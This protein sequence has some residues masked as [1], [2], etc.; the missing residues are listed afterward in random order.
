MHVTAQQNTSAWAK[1]GPM[2]RASADP[3]SPYYGVFVTPGN[4][5]DVQWRSAQGGSA[6]QLTVSG[7]V[8]A[9]LMVGRYTAGGRT[10]YTAY[11]SPDGSTWTAIPGSTQALAM[12]GP[13]LAGFA[14][15]SH[16]Q[17]T[18]SAVTLDS[19]AVS[20]TELAPPGACPS[21]WNCA[22]IG[23][24]LPGPGGQALSGGT[25]NIAGFGN[26]IWGA[27]D[28]FHFVSQS[29]AADGSISA[30]ITSQSNTDPWAKAGLMMRAS[31]D[32]G[33][34]YFAV[35]A[36]PGN[37]I[38]VQWRSAQG[39]SSGQVT[40][41]GTVP[42]YLKITRTGTTFSAYTSPDGSTWTLVPGSTQALANLTGALLRGFA[43]NSHNTGKLGAAVLNSVTTTP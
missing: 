4:G 34:P 31:T 11:T 19:V 17:G 43:V 38:A 1:A 10:Y 12:T 16:N 22:D 36:T 15:T 26:D 14:I 27:A 29:L 8:P 28:S 41:A 35:F 25:W 30:R 23:T 39:G 24:V 9:Y 40:T 20:A 18:A 42:A 33:S 5:I 6:S 7:A 2:V 21:T 37:G 13:L 3:G 32:P